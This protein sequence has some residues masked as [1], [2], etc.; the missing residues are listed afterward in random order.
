MELALTEPQ[1]R[2]VFS[3]AKYPAI[4][5]GL[6]AGKSQAGLVRLILRLL[7]EK[8]NCAYYM[9]TYD[10]IRLRA[11]V[12]A[13]DIL[14]SLGLPHEVNRSTYTI[15]VPRFGDI[16]FR[17]YDNPNRIVSYEVAH[18]IVDELDTLPKTKAAYVWR[19]V[20]ERNRQPSDKANTIGCVTT[21]DQGYSGFVYS[22][23]GQPKANHELIKAPTS[24]N[25]FLPADYEDQIRINY[26]PLLADMYLSGE[27]VSLSRN[28]V[29]H[30]FDRR[31]HHTD[32]TIEPGFDGI[33]NVGLDFNIG[34]TCAVLFIVQGDMVYAVDEFVS[35]HTGDFCVKLAKYRYKNRKIMVYPD[36]S[37][38]NRS[39]N[40]SQSDIQI[41]VAEGFRVD[42]PK[43]NPPIRDRINTVN[44]LLANN[45]LLVNTVKCPH[46]THALEQ[47]GYTDKG[48]PEKFNDH[49]SIDDWADAAGYFLD[50]QFGIRRSVIYTGLRTSI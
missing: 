31:T 20:S 48:E 38:Q 26:D 6:A 3:E 50:R 39:T 43:T 47:Q 33:L 36:S 42:H 8:V 19:K 40:A 16:I 15:S 5:A 45:R 34:G 18:S 46:F 37:G 14:T 9:P 12:G 13:E 29:Y 24:S 23:W 22:R 4:V 30:C 44:G 25:P 17:S 11:M 32:R 21:P 7:E 10:L 41:I 27:F 2:F 35:Q 28:R 1:E 49:P